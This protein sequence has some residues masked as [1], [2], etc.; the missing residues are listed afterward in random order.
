ML[1]AIRHFMF[2]LEVHGKTVVIDHHTLTI[3][4]DKKIGEGE[5]DQLVNYLI[6][7][8]FIEPGFYKVVL[9][10]RK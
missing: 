2:E 9:A 8:A 5:A 4:T 10:I 1:L 7:E 6:N 3:V